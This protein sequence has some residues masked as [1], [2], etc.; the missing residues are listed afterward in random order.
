M[1]LAAR[2]GI[3]TGLVVVGEVGGGARQEL[4]ALGEPPTWPPACKASPHPIPW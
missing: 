3:H 1:H 2:L 4:L